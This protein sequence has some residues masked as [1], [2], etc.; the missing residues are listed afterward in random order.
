M[1]KLAEDKKAK[2]IKLWNNTCGGKVFDA[3]IEDCLDK[4]DYA[5]ASNYSF[6]LKDYMSYFSDLSI[7]NGQIFAN[8]NG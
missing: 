3:S 2:F 4:T 8:Q 6:Y 1:S 7:V 5:I